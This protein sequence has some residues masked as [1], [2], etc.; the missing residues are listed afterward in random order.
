MDD[1]W[2]TF[3]ASLN[4]EALEQERMRP[5]VDVSLERP[6]GP[7]DVRMRHWHDDTRDRFYKALWRA[8]RLAEHSAAVAY[9]QQRRAADIEADQQTIEYQIRAYA[10]KK[11][12]A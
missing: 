6:N 12:A 1:A 9:A 4:P 10:R 5:P 7:E 2:D 11:K 8:E 3:I